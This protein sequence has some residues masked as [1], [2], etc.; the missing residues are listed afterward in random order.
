MQFTAADAIAIVA[1]ALGMAK[2]LTGPIGSALAARIRGVSRTAE[3]TAH[4]AELDEVRGR[5]AEVEE[6]LDFAERL[7][8]RAREADQL[9]GGTHR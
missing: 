8:A 7:L 2:I 4:A 5:L 6:R 9:P 3:D 1:L